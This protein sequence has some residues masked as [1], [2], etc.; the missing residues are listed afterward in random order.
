MR[1]EKSKEKITVATSNNNSTSAEVTTCETS[2]NKMRLCVNLMPVLAAAK[3][4]VEE[5]EVEE[6]DTICEGLNLDTKPP[7]NPRLVLPPITQSKSA[8]AV[9]CDLQKRCHTPLPSISLSEQTKTISSNV[10]IKGPEVVTGQGRDIGPWIDNPL[11]SKSRSPEFRLPDISMSSL[12]TLL[13]TVTEKLAMKKRRGGDE[14]PWRRVQS[15]HHLVVVSEQRLREKS[16]TE[17]R[18][19]DDTK[20]I[21]ETVVVGRGINGWRSVP[22]LLSAPKPTL[23]LTVTKKNIHTSHTLQ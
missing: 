6:D 12:N 9:C 17:N 5:E 21:T 13:Q 19:L 18:N 8:S 1:T 3:E 7:L 15:D 2:G 16:V 20:A 4:P 10:S 11:L 22:P 14:G 23:F